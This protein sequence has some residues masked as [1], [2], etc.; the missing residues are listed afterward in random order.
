MGA[1]T[2]P[3][4]LD[5]WGISWEEYRELVY[6]CLQYDRK[7]READALLTI[8][9][10]TA[11]P[12]TYRIDGREYGTFLPHGT[13]KTDPVAVTAERREKLLHDVHLIETAARQASDQYGEDAYKALL[14]AVTTRDGVR[15]V[16]ASAHPPI[17]ERQFYALRRKF[18]W[19]LREMRS[20]S[21]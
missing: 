17:G 1:S 18:F 21:D 3:I 4:K 13:K 2:R 11:T 12:A 7:K 15:K 16:L 8:P 6:F 20:G 10:T 19:L 5:K 9:S 14:R